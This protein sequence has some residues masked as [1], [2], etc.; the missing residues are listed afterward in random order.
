[1]TMSR[2]QG[3]AGDAWDP[4]AGS[5][6]GISADGEARR[7]RM[8][9][10][11]QGRLMARVRRRRAVRAVGVVGVAAVVVVAGAAVWMGG[12]SGNVGTDAGPVVA[13]RAAEPGNV[14]ERV[15]DAEKG[16]AAQPKVAV[17]RV[18]IQ[19]VSNR[20]DVVERMR[21][22]R[23]ASGEIVRM[24]DRDLLAALRAVGID[25]GLI[26]MKGRVELARDIERPVEASGEPMSLGTE[27]RGGVRG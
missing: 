20:A 1:M 15:V 6:V 21:V 16:G 19:I 22:G 17:P 25:D 14:E 4:G 24:S 5:P 3:D 2:G 8:L 11:L 7:E 27:V 13:E 12:R 10:E 18:M 9:V 26:R 23:G